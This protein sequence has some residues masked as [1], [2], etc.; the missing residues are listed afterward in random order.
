M[1]VGVGVRVGVGVIVGLV[2]MLIASLINSISRP[3]SK[4]KPVARI[5]KGI[6]VGCE[7]GEG[8]GVGGVGVLVGMAVLVGI[9][10]KVRIGVDIEAV[11]VDVGKGVLSNRPILE[12]TIAMTV[13]SKSCLSILLCLG[14]VAGNFPSDPTFTGSTLAFCEIMMGEGVRVG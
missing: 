6:P 14:A 7:M 8:I 5:P 12:S 9:G 3:C 1:C 11:W 4:R 13:D 10:V 2:I